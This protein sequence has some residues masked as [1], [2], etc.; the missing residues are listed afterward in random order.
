MK[1]TVSIIILTWNGLEYTKQCLLSLFEKTK[2]EKYVVYIV[3]NGSTDGTLSYLEDFPYSL[4]IIKNKKNI[5]F[6]A[7]NNLALKMIK[8]GDVILLNNDVIIT[9][10]DWIE[11]MQKTAY[12]EEKVGLVGCRLLDSGQK[13]QH[14]GTYIYPD[15]CIGQQIGG[16]EKE[17]GQ[18]SIDRVVEG[19]VFACVYIKRELI[20]CIG[21]LDERF[22]SYFEDTD[23]CLRTWKA[24]YKCMHCGSVTLIHQ[25]NASTK[26]NHVNLSKMYLESQKI[27]AQ[28]WKRELENSYDI[29]VVWESILNGKSGYA[30][31][32][33]NIVMELSDIK[34]DVRYKYSYNENKITDDMEKKE[35]NHKITL[36]KK[37]HSPKD[38]IH[39]SYCYGDSFQSNNGTYKIGYTMLETTGVPKDWVDQANKMQEIW[40]PSEFNRKTFKESGIK[41]PI[42]VMPLGVDT[43]YYNTAIKRMKKH[44]K[45]TFLSVFEW[46]ERKNPQCLL[47]AYFDAFTKDDNVLLICKINNND[48]SIDIDEEIRKLQLS[49]NG[50]ELLILLNQNFV[51]NEMPMLYR[52]SDCFVLP[53]RGEGWG[54]PILEAMAC[55]LPVITT[56]WGAPLDYMSEEFGYFIRVRGLISA[57]AKCPYYEGFDWAEPSREHLGQLM[58]YVYKNQKEAEMKGKSASQY[59]INNWS[60]KNT[61]MKIKER[62]LKISFNSFRY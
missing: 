59:V 9:Q 10:E 30:V 45:F 62:L 16:G 43:N 18:F 36:I 38:G 51:D 22:F 40:V 44:E 53:T 15:D 5:G 50:P 8:Y 32:S 13:L 49:A 19:V 52:F 46:G 1:N 34:I 60:W 21:G 23:Y 7:G 61:A 47:Q 56:E 26:V 33:R 39:I 41:V 14:A 55:G 57:K 3:D 11:Q 29:T 37:R 28:K 20:E 42:F 6:V 58:H 54:M 2:Y 31:S 27:F 17:F 25:Q 35:D 48:P 24:G 12:S 4:N